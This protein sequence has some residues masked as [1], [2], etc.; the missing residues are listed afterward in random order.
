MQAT[1][2]LE[3][4]LEKYIFQQ[5]RTVFS[6]VNASSFEPLLGWEC[7]YVCQNLRIEKEGI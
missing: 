6:A 2:I 3:V 4:E 1:L 7:A 5:V